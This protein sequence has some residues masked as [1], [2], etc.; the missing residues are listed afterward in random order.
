MKEVLWMLRHLKRSLSLKKQIV[1][2]RRDIASWQRFWKSYNLYQDLAPEEKEFL[3][4]NLYPCL[5]DN[6]SET[7]IEP[8]YF[9]QDCWAFEKIV[10]NK[11]KNHVDVGSHHK[12]VALLSK[13]VPTTMVD[14]RP[15]SLPLETLNFKKGSILELPFEDNSL[16]SVSSL[17]VVEHIGLG[18]YGD[19]LD[20][21]GSIKAIK[22][23]KRVIKDE[24]ELYISVPIDVDNRTYFNAHRAFKE[25][26]LLELFSPFKLTESKYVSGRKF[27][28]FLEEGFCIGC[29]SFRK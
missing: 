24:G 16:E 22:E 1:S 25:D 23:L 21:D 10:N 4:D 2:W 15:L 29:Y 9:Y 18:R 3:I 14:I 17:C 27:N 28:D 11:P 13:V 6:T 8:I 12:F 26:Y 7:N 20:P 19:P 5:G